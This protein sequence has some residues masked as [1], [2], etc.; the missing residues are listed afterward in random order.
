MDLE[1]VLERPA[2]GVRTRPERGVDRRRAAVGPGQLGRL[3]RPVG[4]APGDQHQGGHGERRLDPHLARMRPNAEPEKGPTT[5][6]LLEVWQIQDSN[7]GRHKPAAFTVRSHWP[8]GQSAA[9][10]APPF[11]GAWG[12]RNS[13][14]AGPE[15]RN[16]QEGSQMADSSFDIVSKIDRQE[17]DNALG[18]TARRGRH[19][20]RLQGHRSDHR[21]AGRARDRDQRLGRRPRQRRAR[22]LQ[23]Q[24]DQ[25]PDRA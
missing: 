7:L 17:V 14:K 25:T 16:R 8:L 15:T 6:A 22:R 2:R 4:P 21:V 19:A 3:G 12:G 13:S 24:A 20:V 18:Q 11:G 9:A 10:P 5:E 1:P 23:G